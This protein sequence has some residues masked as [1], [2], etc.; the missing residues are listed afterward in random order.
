MPS[1]IAPMTIKAVALRTGLSVHVIRVWER[2]YQAIV[3]SRSATRRRLYTAEMVERLQLLLRLT[4]QG[5]SIGTVAH[6]GTPALLALVRERERLPEPA[7]QVQADDAGFLEEGLEAVRNLDAS[8]LEQVLTRAE[9][10]L[11]FQGM[12]RRMAAPFCQLLG[13]KWR[14][15]ELTAAHEHLASAVMQSFLLRLS[16]SRS[17]DLSGP[18]LVIATP[19]GQVHEL[20]ALLVCA[21]A[22]NL[23]WRVIYLGANLPA[24]EL[25]GAVRQHQARALALSLVYPEDDTSLPEELERLRQLLPAGCALLA[26]GRAAHSYRP[27]LEKLGTRFCVELS[28]LGQVLDEL[29]ATAIR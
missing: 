10:Q 18:V 25:A 19:R 23:G 8:A 14:E 27:M 15:G 5:R 9:V 20:G 16:R 1:E 2:R 24:A 13:E 22:S 21:A 7:A 17:T 3:P 26:G 29:R 6:L 12:L 11:G 28:Q 4:K